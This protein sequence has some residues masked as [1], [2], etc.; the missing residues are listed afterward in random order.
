MSPKAHILI[1]DDDDRIRD[2]LSK[3]LQKNSFIVTTARDTKE[4]KTALNLF[5]CD[6]VILDVMLPGENGKDF[7][8]YLRSLSPIAI[9]MLTALGE[10]AD[11]IAGLESGA[12]DY[13]P[14]PFEPKELLLR[15]ENLLKRHFS[16]NILTNSITNFGEIAFDSQKKI[17]IKNGHLLKLSNS[18][19]KLLQFFIANIN[20]TITREEIAEQLENINIR[21]VDVQITRLRN[22]IESNP[23][24]PIYLQ[25]VRNKGYILY[26][27]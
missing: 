8:K 17:I 4:A 15:I 14:K 1:V 3:Y 5:Q 12:D 23:K 16:R 9:I 22:K 6:L 25:S 10:S 7:A 19:S 27:D 13:L 11:R 20:K 18:E 24:T 26:A 2:L 21:S